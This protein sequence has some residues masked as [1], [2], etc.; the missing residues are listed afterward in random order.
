M[1]QYD[2]V[3]LG[4]GSAGE[5]V[6]GE[7]AQ[8]GRRVALVE[9]LRVGGECPYVACMPSKAL[10]R[11]AEARHQVGRLVDLGGASSLPRLDGDDE[12]YLA[13]VRRRDEVAEHRDDGE[14]AAGLQD[15]GVE[16]VRGRGRVSAP[17]VVTVADR[18]LGWTDLVLATGS[19]PVVPALDGLDAVPTWI[20][21][22]ALSAQQRPASLLVLGGGAVGCELAQ[23]HAR[24]GVRVV[25]VESGE[26]LLGKEEPGVAAAL[27]EV[28]RSDG[29]EVLLG[30]EAERFSPA[31][32]GRATA[33]LSDGSSREVERVLLAVGRAPVLDGLGLDVLGIDELRVDGHCRVTENVWAAGDLT[34]VAPYTHTASYQARVVVANLLG[35]ERVADY[36]AIPRVVYTD[37]P[38]AS[39]GLD[40]R[41]ASGSGMD[42]VTAVMDLA[43]V[44]RTTTEGSCG[45]RLVLTCD[46][47]RGVLVGA[48][49]LGPRA[50]DWIGEATLAIRAEVPLAVLVDVVHP[51][52]TFGEAYEPALRELAEQVSAASS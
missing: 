40:A 47:A 41:A 48:A 30:V 11:S 1:E 18:Q 31:P 36:R 26:Q 17:G 5:V 39:V 45:G 14:A 19:R 50:D 51:F 23:A 20:S 25:L 22:E 7:L 49:A 44:A 28:L 38:V 16:V 21:D 37:P 10:L 33:H 12:G 32:G 2:V 42:A 24:F 52:P 9:A 43:Q 15:R 4:G 13:A 29:V 6:A 27:A 8:A 35:T 34:G 46:R 3:V